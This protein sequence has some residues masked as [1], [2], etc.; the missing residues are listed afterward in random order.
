[1]IQGHDRQPLSQSPDSGDCRRQQRRYSTECTGSLGRRRRACAGRGGGQRTP[2]GKTRWLLA[3]PSAKVRSA[4]PVCAWPEPACGSSLT[5]LLSA[6]CHGGV[7]VFSGGISNRAPT[8]RFP[9]RVA[10]FRLQA[11]ACLPTGAFWP[12]FSRST[13]RNMP[14]RSFVRPLAP[15]PNIRARPCHGE[16]WRT[17]FESCYIMVASPTSAFCS[18]FV[19]S[20]RPACGVAKT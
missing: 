9:L 19:D 14:P 18:C 12:C 17:T 1:M 5:R 2:A 4:L 3:V 8:D 13:G 6:A 7:P 11:E 20:T 15:L 16:P 10:C